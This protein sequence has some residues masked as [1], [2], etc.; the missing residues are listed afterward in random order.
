MVGLNAMSS[1]AWL[2]LLSALRQP[3]A[4]RTDDLERLFARGQ[5]IAQFVN[6]AGAQRDLWRKNVSEAGAATEFVERL[7]HAGRGLRL[8]VVTEDWCLDSV[9]TVPYLARLAASAQIPLRII[10]RAAGAAVMKQHRAPDGR[11]V[12]PTVVF[13]RDGRDAGAWIERPAPLQQLFLTMRANPRAAERFADRQA[14]YDADR[15]RT[16][17]AEIVAL[18]ET[19][20]SGR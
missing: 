7:N 18:A 10:D 12:T 3:A 15:G 4:A 13:L 11:T 20:A 17:L 16:T 2:L 14:W 8:L 5:T 1:I 6:R 19:I 9:N